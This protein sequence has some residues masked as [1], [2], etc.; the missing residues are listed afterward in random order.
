MKIKGRGGVER[1]CGRKGKG[2]RPKKERVGERKR[3][4]VRRW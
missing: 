2:K 1:S 4:D 3:E